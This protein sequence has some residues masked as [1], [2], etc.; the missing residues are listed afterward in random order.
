M[1][2]EKY[3]FQNGREIQSAVWAPIVRHLQR[4][5]PSL[6]SSVS[7]SSQGNN[8]SLSRQT[9]YILLLPFPVYSAE[10]ILTFFN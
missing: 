7:S 9:F 4:K 2:A 1:K 8:L 6:Q 3:G 5:E 10:N